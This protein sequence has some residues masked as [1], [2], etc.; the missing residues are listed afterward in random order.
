MFSAQIYNSNN[1]SYLRL[2]PP[3]VGARKTRKITLVLDKSGS[4]GIEVTAGTE[5]NGFTR[6]ILVVHAVKTIINT[7]TETDTLALIT[8]DSYSNLILAPTLMT[9]ANKA[10]ALALLDNISP[11]GGTTLFPAL[12]LA[13]QT[14]GEVL[15]LT[16]G[17]TD[18]PSQGFIPALQ[19]E[20]QKSPLKNAVHTIGFTDAVESELLEDIARTCM[21]SFLFIPS[22]DMVGTIIINALGNL[23]STFATNVRV[24]V[25]SKTVQVGSVAYGQERCIQLDQQ[26]DNGQQVTVTYDSLETNQTV[27]INADFI[28]AALKDT[29]NNNIRMQVYPTIRK[30]MNMFLKDKQ[31]ARNHIAAFTKEIQQAIKLLKDN[32]LDTQFLQGIM[33]DFDGGEDANGRAFEGQI[34]LAFSDNYFNTWGKHW[35]ISY[36]GA[37]Q[38]QIRNN[39]KDKGVQNYGGALFTQLQT[40][41]TDIFAN[42]PPPEPDR[43]I[44]AE[45][46]LNASQGYG[47]RHTQAT[48]MASYVDP[49]GGC[50]H[51]NCS[52]KMADGTFKLVKDVRIGDKLS[53]GSVRFVTKFI[54]DESI[55][56]IQ[57][58]QIGDLLVTPYHPIKLDNNWVFP[59]DVSPRIVIEVI[60]DAVY[61]FV[62]DDNHTAEINNITCVT[63]GHTFT[64]SVVKHDYFGSYKVINDIIDLGIDSDGY[65]VIHH[66]YITRNN[67]TNEISSIKKPN[68]VVIVNNNIDLKTLIQV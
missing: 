52:V 59:R 64:E 55:G 8:F 65:T 41:I 26:V 30:A 6:W 58:V 62:L 36:I 27:S 56:L 35:L 37:H 61:D 16:D 20:F 34:P 21:G 1:A 3:T 29:T 28:N 39:F 38:S 42:I 2:V 10:R 24:N 12:Q 57:M 44:V 5:R 17:A 47:T 15:V 13:F 23:L 50:F 32:N 49:T 51:G 46:N 33:E 54:I 68:D 22:G 31:Q 9:N 60:T 4:M 7:L 18:K 45:I 48:T 53:T 11:G 14:G 25:G 19:Q 40:L 43:A 67:V 63:L 66:N